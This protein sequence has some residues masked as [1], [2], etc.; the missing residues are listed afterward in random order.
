LT[1]TAAVVARTWFVDRNFLPSDHAL[2]TLVVLSRKVL[3]ADGHRRRLPMTHVGGRAQLR[4]VG[5]NSL[6]GRAMPRQSQGRQR[7]LISAD[8]ARYDA[9]SG[10]EGV[11]CAPQGVG[12]EQGKKVWAVR[13]CE[14]RSSKKVS[15]SGCP[16]GLY[17]FRANKRLL[18]VTADHMT[19]HL[20]CSRDINFDFAK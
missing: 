7:Y 1:T 16:A 8:V 11:S 6:Y 15:F 3:G 5:T 14:D 17:L 18:V 9:F 20:R 4:K 19:L 10:L 13:G 12:V 2:S